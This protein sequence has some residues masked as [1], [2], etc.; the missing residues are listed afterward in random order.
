MPKETAISKIQPRPTT[1]LAWGLWVIYLLLQTAALVL[2]LLTRSYPPDANDPLPLFS[3]AWLYLPSN[4]AFPTIGALIATRQPRNPIGWLLLC[5]GLV[6][7]FGQFAE[8]YWRYALFV[9][10]G[11]LPAGELMLWVNVRPYSIGALLSVLLILFFPTGHPP[12]RRWWIVGW[13]IMFG[14]LMYFGALAF[15]PG[16]LDVSVSITNPFGLSGAATFLQFCAGLGA[17]IQLLGVLGAA[18]SLIVRF[19]RANGVER[20][21]IKLLAYALVIYGV[22]FGLINYLIN[23][24]ITPT[25]A[26]SL[27]VNVLFVVQAL[28]AV[29]VAVAAGIAILRYRLWDIDIIIRRTLVYSLLTL[30]LGLVYLGCI[31]MSRTLVAP[32]VGGSELGIVASTLAIAAL[33]NPLRRRIQNLI[34]KRFYRRKY[35]A[36]KVLAAFGATA[37]DE[38][39]LERL[40][41]EMLRVVDET[42]RPEFVGLWLREPA[43]HSSLDSARP[44]ATSARKRYNEAHN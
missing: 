2:A 19:R 4:F 17:Y 13:L 3:R 38:T 36:A 41:A 26:P 23:Y 40:N 20:Q 35:D 5:I 12:S 39:D 33:F 42:M 16:P 43:T 8:G 22:S 34:D 21:Q 25:E 11:A 6:G 44:D 9:R 29:F 14:G 28:A 31:L 32:Y 18:L 27:L 10:P 1:R 15:M 30:T 24:S 7:V 37:R